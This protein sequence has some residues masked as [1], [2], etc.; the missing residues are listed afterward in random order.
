M[1]NPMNLMN[2]ESLANQLRRLDELEIQ[3]VV[4]TGLDLETLISKFAEG[5]ILVKP[6]TNSESFEELL[7]EGCDQ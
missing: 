3:L 1:V 6:Q 2:L 7:K 5:Y 4:L